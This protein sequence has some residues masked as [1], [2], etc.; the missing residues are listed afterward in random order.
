MHM[1]AHM[2]VV[3]WGIKKEA[4]ALALAAHD[5]TD[6]AGKSELWAAGKGGV[7]AVKLY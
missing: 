6:N 5:A 3:V 2:Y 4:S 7:A 1:Y